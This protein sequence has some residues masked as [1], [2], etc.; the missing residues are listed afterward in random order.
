M[1]LNEE[2]R[3][4]HQL[5]EEFTADFFPNQIVIAAYKRNLNAHLDK[6]LGSNLR[7]RLSDAIASIVDSAKS[8]MTSLCLDILFLLWYVPLV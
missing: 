4:L 1:A 3:R 8:T 5:V 6:G 7:A 2:I